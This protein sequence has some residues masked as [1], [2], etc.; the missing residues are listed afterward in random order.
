M[1]CIKLGKQERSSELWSKAGLPG[2]LRYRSLGFDEHIYAQSGISASSAA[3]NR[4]NK[5]KYEGATVVVAWRRSPITFT[6]DEVRM[7]RALV[8]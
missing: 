2:T 4:K 3:S 8:L 7:H 5:T 1:H 6:G